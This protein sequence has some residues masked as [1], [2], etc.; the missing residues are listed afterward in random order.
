MQVRGPRRSVVMEL[1]QPTGQSQHELNSL[2]L[3]E[4]FLRDLI[5]QRLLRAADAGRAGGT[6]LSFGHDSIFGERS[7]SV[8]SAHEVVFT[9]KKC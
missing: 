2:E 8:A 3:V 1:S 4:P 6:K 5:E 9:E 7:V